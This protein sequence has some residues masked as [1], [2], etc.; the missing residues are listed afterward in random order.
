MMNFI[1]QLTFSEIQIKNLKVINKKLKNNI[2]YI[3][4]N[5]LSQI[6]LIL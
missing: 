5:K 4:E 3:Q 1:I 2:L 6:Y